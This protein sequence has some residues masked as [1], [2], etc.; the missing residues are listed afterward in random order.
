VKVLGQDLARLSSSKRD[1]FRA[2]HLGIVFQM[3]NLLPYLSVTDNVCLPCRFSTYRKTRA[4]HRHDE[5]IQ[6]EAHRLLHQLHLDTSLWGRP[7]STL[8][9]GQQQRVA[10][11]RALIGKP[12]VLIADEP[13]SALDTDRRDAFLDLLL[14]ECRVEGTS[15]IFVSH[16]RSLATHFDRH[17]DMDEINTLSTPSLSLQE[18][19][20]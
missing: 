5:T 19:H 13:T 15:L 1:Q 16:D 2:D 12:E 8:S 20:A 17:L 4:R 10:V 7:V 3:F 6:Q 11:A 18:V 9:V 14:N